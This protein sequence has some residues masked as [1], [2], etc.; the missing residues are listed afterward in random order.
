MRASARAGRVEAAPLARRRRPRVV[1]RLR[2]ALRAARDALLAGAILGVRALLAPVPL[3]AAVAFC[4]ALGA[5]VAPWTGRPWRWANAHLAVAFPELP[6]AR[7]AAIARRAF[8]HAGMSFAE[9]AK[10]RAV[11]RR[12]AGYVAAEGLEHLREG[13]ARGRG[14]LAVT[15]HCGNWELLAAYCA[16]AGLPVTVIGRRL[17][18]ALLNRLLIRFRAGAGVTTIERESPGSSRAILSTLRAGRI[19]ALLIDQDTRGPRVFV[20]FFGR[21][22]STPAGAAALALR[23]GAPVV[24]IFISRRPEGGHVIRAHP[25]LPAVARDGDTVES[26]TTAYTAAI[27]RHVRRHPEEWVWWHRRWRRRPAG[28]MPL[29]KNP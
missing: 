8:A 11:R 18:G 21:P 17:H 4:G 13:L 14:L 20:P 1:R 10:F 6:P 3:R 27:E 26:L 24:P 22:A 2:R 12:M 25:A 9:I 15:G 23:T 5:A 16:R 28:A 29:S 7:R 19:L